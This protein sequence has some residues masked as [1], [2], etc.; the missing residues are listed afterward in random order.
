MCHQLLIKILLVLLHHKR[1]K[2]RIKTRMHSSGMRITCLLTVS[3]HALHSVCVCPSMH[4]A[5][6]VCIPAR[7]GQGGVCLPRG[8]L[9]KGG[10]C[11][12]RGCLPRRGVPAQRG[13]VCPG[14]VSVWW[15]CLPRGVSAWGC[16][17][18]GGCTCPGGVPAWG[19]FVQGGVYP[20]MQWADTPHWTD[21]HL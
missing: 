13:C 18:L 9:P 15:V 21:R 10:R 2:S 17:C 5:G 8:V 14:G 19:V 16:V 3:Q 4:W 1:T 12:P 7:T 11:L 6:G 20:S